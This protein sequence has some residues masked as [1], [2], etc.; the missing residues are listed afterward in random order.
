MTIL[1]RLFQIEEAPSC[2]D[3]IIRFRQDYFDRYGHDLKGYFELDSLRAESPDLVAK[4]DPHGLDF[5]DLMEERFAHFVREAY[6]RE[7]ISMSRAGE[8]LNLSIME[9]RALVRT[10]KE[11]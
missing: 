2:S 4:E 8:M 6:E 5:S 3:L 9:M 10:W 7:I 1:Y 11:L